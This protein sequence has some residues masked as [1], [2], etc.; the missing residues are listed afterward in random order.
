MWFISLE[1]LLSF[2]Q[3]GLKSLLAPFVPLDWRENLSL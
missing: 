2:P 3:S 1:I